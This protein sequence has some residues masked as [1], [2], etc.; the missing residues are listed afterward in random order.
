MDKVREVMM[1]MKLRILTSIA[2]LLIAGTVSTLSPPPASALSVEIGP[3]EL[4]LKPG[5]EHSGYIIAANE[6]SEPVNLKIYLGDWLQTETGEQYLDVGEVEN[7][8]SQW[9]RVSPSYVTIPPGGEE[10]IYYE[11]KI[12]DDETLTG[13]YWGIFFVEE[14][15]Q[16]TNVEDDEDNKPTIGL[17]IVLRHGIKVYV[18]IP[19]TDE[20]KAKF[21]KAWTEK[22]PEGGLDFYA[23]FENMGNTYLRPDVWI[24]LRDQ[25]GESVFSDSHRTLTILPGVKRDYKFELRDLD[26]PKGR[27]SALIIADYGVLSLIGAQAEIEV[28]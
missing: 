14:E 22:P 17:N 10:R 5:D 27:Y 3:I 25:T 19:G 23:T 8:L 6:E 9:M 11:I 7:S 28:E 20:P 2:V 16:K 26:L 21:V 13:S 24:E 1:D 18:T 12:P 15:S 4:R